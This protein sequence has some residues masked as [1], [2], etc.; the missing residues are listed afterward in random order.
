MRAKR[1]EPKG[2]LPFLGPGDIRAGSRSTHYEGNARNIMLQCFT[3]HRKHVSHLCSVSVMYS[4]TKYQVHT[5]F[6]GAFRG[7]Y[8]LDMKHP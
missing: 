2:S 6:S 3:F 7:Y 8:S 1:K 5:E 4:Y